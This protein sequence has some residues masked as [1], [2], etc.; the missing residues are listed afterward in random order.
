MAC[1]TDGVLRAAL[2]GELSPAELADVEEHGTSCARCRERCYE[3]AVEAERVRTGLSSLAPPGRDRPLDTRAAIAQFRARRAAL[4][5]QPPS[6]ATAFFGRRWGLATWG[7]A[8]ACLIVALLT[9]AP[10]RSWAQRFAAMLRVQKITAVPLDFESLGNP[11]ER[12]RLGK[13]FAQMLSD[14]VVMT[15]KPGEPQAMAS[16]EQSTAAAGFN[17]MLLGGRQ[18]SPRLKLLGEQS[19]HATIDRDR[20]QAVIEEA[21]RSDLKVPDALDGATIAAY[22]PKIVIAEYG[23]CPHRRGESPSEPSAG[24]GSCVEFLQAPSPT[25]TVP[26][27]LDLSQLAEVALQ[28]GGMSAEAAR[29]FSQS[30]DWG[31]TVVLGIPMGVSYRTVEVQG[32]QGTLIERAARGE[33]APRGYS[34]LWVKNGIVYAL[35]G[36][37]DPADALTLAESLN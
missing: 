22:I 27:E 23:A 19:F 20:L 35:F 2:D 24:E 3:L 17:V 28:L 10:A 8:A 25:V 12:R 11:S 26:P 18:D 34:L 37:G 5:N 36:G 13:T 9:F 30:V 33:R 6:F 32:V 4:A 16:R 1:L 21:G 7:L 31:S 14:D 29:G 15:V